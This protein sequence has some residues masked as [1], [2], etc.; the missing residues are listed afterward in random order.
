VGISNGLQAVIERASA[1]DL[2]F[3]AMGGKVPQQFAVILTLE[4]SAD[5]QLRQFRR[6]IS[7]RILAIRR[8]RQRLIQVPPG[9]GH[10]V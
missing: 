2:A 1:T 4:Q 7:D 8:L 6:L 3:L 10:P 5:F 9:C